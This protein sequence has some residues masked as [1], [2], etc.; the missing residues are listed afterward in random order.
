MSE[1]QS[2]LGGGPVASSTASRAARDQTPHVVYNAG[3]NRIVAHGVL[4]F[5]FAE[6]LADLLDATL[7][8]QPEHIMLDLTDVWLLDA[9]TVRVL[10][11]YQAQSA[12]AGCA[13]HIVGATGVVRRV[14]EITGVLSATT[15]DP[16]SLVSTTDGIHLPR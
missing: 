5:A 15:S 16:P 2:D 9:S 10:L 13:V 14:L 12:A 4:D 7:V 6:H 3:R 8:D 11:A 1:P